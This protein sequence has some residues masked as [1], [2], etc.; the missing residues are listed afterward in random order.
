MRREPY[1]RALAEMAEALHAANPNAERAALDAALEH[2]RRYLDGARAT[3]DRY[4]ENAEHQELWCKR[5][6]ERLGR[7]R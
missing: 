3:G 2:W 7:R 6:L 4:R 5:R 1:Y